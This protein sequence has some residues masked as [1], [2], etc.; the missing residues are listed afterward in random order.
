MLETKAY[1]DG[2]LLMLIDTAAKLPLEKH[3]Y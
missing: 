1:Y 2:H 3:V